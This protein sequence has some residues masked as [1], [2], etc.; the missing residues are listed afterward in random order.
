MRVDFQAPGPSDGK[1][2]YTKCSSP[3]E[4]ENLLY[5]LEYNH[6]KCA[7]AVVMLANGVNFFTSA[8][9]DSFTIL[10]TDHTK[11]KMSGMDRSK[12]VVR[13]IIPDFSK[14]T[15]AYVLGLVELLEIIK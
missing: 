12:Q 15:G 8:E 3:E 7:M 1:T 6:G 5:R 10:W 4:I 9:V 2:C 11:G 13:E 14:V